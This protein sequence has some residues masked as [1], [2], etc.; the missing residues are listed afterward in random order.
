MAVVNFTKFKYNKNKP[1]QF[2]PQDKDLRCSLANIQ[3]Q[4]GK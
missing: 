4:E 3:T 1:Q 2:L